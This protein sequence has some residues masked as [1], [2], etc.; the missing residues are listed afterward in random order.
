M[1]WNVQVVFVFADSQVASFRSI[2]LLQKR[3][4]L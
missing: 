3:Q 4:V 2:R 1:A